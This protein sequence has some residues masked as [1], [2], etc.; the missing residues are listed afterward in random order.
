MT[1][2]NG[3]PPRPATADQSPPSSMEGPVSIFSYSENEI[4][5]AAT[6]ERAGYLVLSEVWYPG[7]RATINGAPASVLRANYTLR[8]LPVPAGD[9]EVRLW[10]APES[11][12]RGLALFGVGILLL[13]GLFLWRAVALKE[14]NVQR[15]N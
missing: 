13:A 2:H 9:I 7:W 4:V 14:R 12:R 6:A 8:A 10:Y 11:W 3:N 15:G 1:Q 5:L